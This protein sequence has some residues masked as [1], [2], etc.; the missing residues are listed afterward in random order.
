[1]E[2]FFQALTSLLP[3]GY[4]WPRDPSSVLMRL[5]R[6]TAGAFGELQAWIEQTVSQWQPHTAVNRL[7]EWEAAVGLPDACFGASQSEQ[8]R[9]KLL[10]G[11]LR[12]AALEFEDSSP[13]CFAAIVT[14]CADLGYP[15]TVNYNLPFRV[16]HQVGQWLGALDGQLYITVTIQASVFRCGDPVGK[17]LL[18]GALNGAELSCFLR[19]VLPARFNAN[20]IFV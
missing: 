5:M 20:F 2:R 15:A 7:A 3:Q 4:A 12:R 16:G 13:A 9:R 11:R 14:L 1:M 6:A 19:R 10:L 17:R 8:L 18:D